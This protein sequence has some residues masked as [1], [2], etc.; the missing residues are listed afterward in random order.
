MA[1]KITNNAE[2]KKENLAP[3]AVSEVSNIPHS[4]IVE[5][6]RDT[7]EARRDRDENGGYEREGQVTVYS[8][9]GVFLCRYQSPNSKYTDLQV[10]FTM[11]SFGRKTEFFMNFQPVIYGSEMY[12]L[13]NN[14]FGEEDYIEAEVTKTVNDY[15]NGKTVSWGLQV[16]KVDENGIPVTVKL[17]TRNTSDREAWNTY[18]KYLEVMGKF[19]GKTT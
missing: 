1:E 16:T 19:K 6:N 3:S 14:M 7:F 4:F 5:G 18:I 15:G 2:N 12:A 11:N 8:G 10:G 13:L 17:K 9:I